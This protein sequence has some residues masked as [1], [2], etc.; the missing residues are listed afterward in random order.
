MDSDTAHRG[1]LLYIA[2]GFPG[3]DVP[4]ATMPP[5]LRVLHDWLDF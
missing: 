1:R 5:R 4:P 3:L 2:L